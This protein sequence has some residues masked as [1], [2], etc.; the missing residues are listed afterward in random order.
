MVTHC[1]EQIMDYTKNLFKKSPSVTLWILLLMAS[2][3]AVSSAVG[4][5]AARIHIA[6][7]S[8]SQ[9]SIYR[10]V[11]NAAQIVTTAVSGHTTSP[12]LRLTD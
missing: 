8:D 6:E 2:S 11:E 9:A 7:Q 4:S 5:L 1:C 3:F 12:P 10:P